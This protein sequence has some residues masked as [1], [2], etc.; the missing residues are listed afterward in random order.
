VSS[1]CYPGH[2]AD[3][4]APLALGACVLI[5]PGATLLDP[6]AMEELSAKENVAGVILTPKV[7]W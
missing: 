5:I 3:L 1:A 7:G 6:R 4:W 2:V